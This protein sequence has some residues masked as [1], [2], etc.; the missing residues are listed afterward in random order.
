MIYELTDLPLSNCSLLDSASASSEAM[1]VAF[2]YHKQKRPLFFCDNQVHPVLK[3]T[4]KTRAEFVGL[5][6]E[7]GDITTH[8]FYRSILW[9]VILISRY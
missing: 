7:F 1:S 6:V 3:E 8:N 4:L 2:N 9:C 5:T